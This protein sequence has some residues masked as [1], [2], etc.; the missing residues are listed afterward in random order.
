VRRILLILVALLIACV[1]WLAVSLSTP[2]GVARLWPYLPASVQ[3][4]PSIYLR[5]ALGIIERQSAR[6]DALDWSKTE[7]PRAEELA[8]NART[9]ADTYPAIRDV[10]EQ[11]KDGHSSLIPPTTSNSGPQGAFG[12]TTLYPDNV[13]A[14]V[15]PNSAAAAAGI[16]AGDIIEQ[17]N[18]APPAVST[19]PRNRGYFLNI[20]PPQATLRIRH[21]ED[22]DA[23]DVNLTVGQYAPLPALVQRRGPENKPDLGYVE[24]PATSG[25]GEFAERVRE[26]ILEKDAPTVCGWIVD[27]RFDNGGEMWA[28]LQTL[29][30]IL[31]EPPLGSFVSPD[32]KAS[33]W[34]FPTSGALGLAK[35][36]KALNHPNPPVAVLTSR[37]T[38]RAGELTAIAFRGRQDTRS[39]GEPTWGAPVENTSYQLPDGARLDLATAK[40]ADRTGHVYDGRIAP[41]QSVP[42]DWANLTGEK[43]PVIV[44]AGTWL[45]TLPACKK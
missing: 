16:R 9:A 4:R 24:I 7:I 41:D 34:M 15:Y 3:T 40:A 28:M 38:S 45:R 12:F 10:L 23:H 27:L 35:A 13:V 42:I 43:D 20:P 17:V 44:A 18:G 8:K 36:D 21:P 31:G 22:K 33:A 11:L 30:P 5:Y 25:Q 19:E 2:A 29:R 26:N 39:F 32:G 37:L 6:R 1:V 14:V